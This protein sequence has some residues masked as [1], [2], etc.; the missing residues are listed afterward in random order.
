[1]SISFTQTMQSLHA[2]HGRSALWGMGL[3]MFFLLLWLLWFLIPSLSVYTQGRL[4]KL[5]RNGTVVAAIPAADWAHLQAGQ[6]AY[7]FPTDAA[8]AQPRLT[9]MVMEVAT[10][11]DDNQVE[12]TLYPTDNSDWATLFADSV[13]GEVQVEVATISPARVLLQTLQQWGT[14]STVSLSPQQR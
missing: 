13:N 6:T 7:L 8:A 12:I 4:V 5:T 3:A 2:D 11:P 1:M 9:A 10:Q 14:T